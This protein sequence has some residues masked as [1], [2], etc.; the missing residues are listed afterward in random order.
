MKWLGH[1]IRVLCFGFCIWLCGISS[2]FI[3]QL[4]EQAEMNKLPAK[5]I[6]T[7]KLN[8]FAPAEISALTEEQGDLVHHL[9]ITS[10]TSAFYLHI[11]MIATTFA[12]CF[13]VK[14]NGLQ[15]IDETKPVVL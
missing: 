11:A 7:L 6:E 5:F 1:C 8:V 13:V 9:Y 10:I 2:I 12:A 3:R 15:C 14:D 4:D